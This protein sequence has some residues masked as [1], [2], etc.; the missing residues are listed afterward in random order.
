MLGQHCLNV[1]TYT[2][3]GQG[4][5]QSVEKSPLCWLNVDATEVGILCYLTGNLE[6]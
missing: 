6:V 5:M 3:A 4:L 1:K 2:K